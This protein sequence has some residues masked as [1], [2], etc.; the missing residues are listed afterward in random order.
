MAADNHNMPTTVRRRLVKVVV[1][2]VAVE[3]GTE[4][5]WCVFFH[6]EWTEKAVVVVVVV[7]PRQSLLTTTTTR[8]SGSSS[9]IPHQ[10]T[11]QQLHSQ[12]QQYVGTVA[13]RA[14]NV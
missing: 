12:Q 5:D 14:K 6:R 2:A 11:P 1:E 8:R 7:E 9:I 13:A 4:E 10:H 3:V